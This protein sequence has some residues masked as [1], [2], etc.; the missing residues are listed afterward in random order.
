MLGNFDPTIGRSNYIAFGRFNQVIWLSFCL[1]PRQVQEEMH[2]FAT[3]FCGGL[4]STCRRKTD[5]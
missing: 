5:N 2:A 1:W 4:L 3:S